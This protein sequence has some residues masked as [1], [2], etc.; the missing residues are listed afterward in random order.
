MCHSSLTHSVHATDVYE[1]KSVSLL[2]I[3]QNFS[4]WEG[5]RVSS[6]RYATADE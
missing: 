6:I 2:I 1:L 4:Q 3:F 5:A